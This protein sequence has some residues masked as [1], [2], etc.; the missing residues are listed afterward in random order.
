M[1][2]CRNY[3]QNWSKVLSIQGLW[4][5]LNY[6]TTV[7]SL[8]DFITVIY[9]KFQTFKISIFFVMIFKKVL[10]DILGPA[11][12]VCIDICIVSDALGIGDLYCPTWDYAILLIHSIETWR[13]LLCARQCSL[14]IK[15]QT[16]TPVYFCRFIIFFTRL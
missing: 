11:A 3:E 16:G 6:F 14:K 9:V 2:G 5:N 13:I 1:L 8:C 10:L 7:S 15:L 4:I 12:Y